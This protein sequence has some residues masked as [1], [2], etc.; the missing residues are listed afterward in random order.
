LYNSLILFSNNLILLFLFKIVCSKSIILFE[1]FTSD[2]NDN[3]FS[4][5]LL[6]SFKFK[7]LESVVEI[8]EDNSNS[9]RLVSKKSSLFVS[10]LLS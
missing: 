7:S 9:S 10:K 4:C 6:K 8:F 5:K 2:S 1:S 3:V